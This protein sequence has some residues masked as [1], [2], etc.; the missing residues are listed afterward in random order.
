MRFCTHIFHHFCSG[1]DIQGDLS[2]ESLV[3]TEERFGF[4]S[5]VTSPCFLNIPNRLS[6]VNS[7]N[8]SMIT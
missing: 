3:I 8:I 2:K 6:D 4:D 1:I 5:M 7:N